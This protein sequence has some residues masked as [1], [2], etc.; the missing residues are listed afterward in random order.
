MRSRLLGRRKVGIGRYRRGLI[1]RDAEITASGYGDDSNEG[2]GLANRL[3]GLHAVY[4]R[5]D[6]VG[7][8]EIRRSVTQLFQCVRRILG[9][10]RLISGE[11]EHA[12]DRISYVALIIDDQYSLHSASR[13]GG[14]RI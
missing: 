10:N 11:I 3:D 6:D 9:G 4:L 13:I 8:D 1:A 2:K 5:H 7:D 14:D 12:F